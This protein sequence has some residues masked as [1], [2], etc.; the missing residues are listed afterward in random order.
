M[1]AFFAVLEDPR[2]E[3]GTQHLLGDVLV[4]ALCAVLAGADS[5]QQIGTFA[6]RKKA[7]LERFLKLP[8]GVPSHDTFQRVFAAL[9]A[10]AFEDC[11]IAWMNAACSA[12]GLQPIH[13]DGKTSR[14]CRRR[15]KDG[16]CPALHLVS[17]WA[18]ANRLTLGQVA[19][20]EKSN[21]I[22]AI[23]KLLEVLDLKGCIVT[24]DAMGCQKEIAR[25]IK[26]GGGDYV[27]AVKDNQPTLHK[28]VQEVFEKALDT[29]FKGLDHE[30]FSSQTK[31]R[32]RQ[33]KRTYLVIRDP[34][35]LS[36]KDEWQGLKAV[37]MV[38][39]E[40]QQGEKYSLE[41]GYYISSADLRGAQWEEVIRGHWS[42]ESMHWVLDV[43]FKEDQN[44]T[45]DRNA[46][47]N[48]ALVRKVALSLLKA[49]PGKDSMPCRR[50]SAACDEHYLEQALLLLSTKE[51][52]QPPDQ[53]ASP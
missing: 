30:A 45:K 11:F 15:G 51:D 22:T 44:R 52:S 31:G 40:R 13:I 48:L 32:G 1:G 26:E 4:I 3:H 9:D 18:G 53:D 5:W 25:Q 17:A 10:R 33:E 27:L 8:N 35:G 39:R 6:V 41:S 43:V 12:C 29:D 14:G 23:P 16:L 19:C 2:R 49:M 38:T 34:A 50:L 21:E 36:T 47:T 7:W 20:S 46:A 28:D 24:I 42:I 37:V